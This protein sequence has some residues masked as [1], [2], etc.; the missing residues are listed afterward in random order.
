MTAQWLSFYGSGYKIE[1]NGSIHTKRKSF[2][3]QIRQSM[4]SFS[5]R[6]LIAH[7]LIHVMLKWR[8]VE[9]SGWDGDLVPIEHKKKKNDG[10]N[11]NKKERKKWEKKMKKE[12]GNEKIHLFF[13]FNITF[14][15]SS[16]LYF[17][18]LIFIESA[19]SLSVRVHI[20][21]LYL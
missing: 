13:L 3:K 2:T 17:S 16:S 4:S 18:F 20:C 19:L 14:H 21:R 7:Y 12:N 5:V 9:E 6:W 11:K 8:K 15:H 10:N 1:Y